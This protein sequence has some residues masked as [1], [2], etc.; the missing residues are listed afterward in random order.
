METWPAAAFLKKY[1]CQKCDKS[2]SSFAQS[3]MFWK[4]VI[5]YTYEKYVGKSKLT[6]LERLYNAQLILSVMMILY[7]QYIISYEIQMK[8]FFRTPKINHLY[9]FNLFRGINLQ[10]KTMFAFEIQSG[11]KRYEKKTL[12]SS[13]SS[14]SSSWLKFKSN[15]VTSALIDQLFFLLLL[16]KVYLALAGFSK[17]SDSDFAIRSRDVVFRHSFCR[18]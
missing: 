4:F 13:S 6:R 16:S 2:Q 12:S 10:G 15:F 9:L 3:F 18:L 14:S 5:Y 1:F 7:A 17:R 8:F 11:V